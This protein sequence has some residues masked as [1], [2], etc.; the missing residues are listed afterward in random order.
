MRILIII[1]LLSACTL[2]AADLKT[3]TH[4]LGISFQYPADWKI[5]ESPFTDLEMVPPNAGSNDRG[6]TETYFLMTF[7]MK[8]ADGSGPKLTEQLEAL[9]KQ[10][11]PF[12]TPMGD[13]EPLK[14]PAHA[15]LL[16]WHGQTPAGIEAEADI[17]SV[18]GPNLSYCL[19]ALGEQSQIKSREASLREIVTT[20]QTPGG[21]RDPKLVGAWTNAED[22]SAMTLRSDGGFTASQ[23]AEGDTQTA[24]KS[25]DE[26]KQST[27]GYWFAGDGKLF[28]VATNTTTLSF[29]YQLKGKQGAR[30]L[31]LHHPSGQEQVLREVRGK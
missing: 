10:I 29:S 24:S 22:K 12:L 23:T 7:G 3:Y 19:I 4:P 14:I 15:V 6:P 13:T 31:T 11:A 28:L 25:D 30:T 27:G 18:P 21:T 5:R 2:S 17:Y 8:V 1:L 9:L 26:E 16:R 20:F